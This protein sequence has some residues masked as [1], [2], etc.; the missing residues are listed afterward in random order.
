MK[1]IIQTSI[2]ALE[3]ETENVAIEEILKSLLE[4]ITSYISE[5]LNIIP[6]WQIRKISIHSIELKYGV[7][8]GI[9]RKGGEIRIAN[10]LIM[11]KKSR[12]IR[13][14]L[15]FVVVKVSLIQFITNE[16]DEIEEAFLN[17]LT[18]LWL[19]E[20]F[21]IQST[22]SVIF[23]AI[24]SRIYS[25]SID[26]IDYTHFSFFLNQLFARKK[27]FKEVF[28]VYRNFTEVESLKGKEL[29]DALIKWE[30]SLYSDLEIIAPIYLNEQLHTTI[31]LLLELGCENANVETIANKMNVHPNTVRRNYKI[32][33]DK[34]AI[35]WSANIH[36]EKLNLH[37]YF[38]KII[39]NKT[40]N[41]EKLTRIVW[42]KLPYNN[43]IFLGEM[44][45][46]NK[47]IYS[48]TLFCPHIVAENLDAKLTKLSNLGEITDYS[49]REI[50]EKIHY[51]AITTAPTSPTLKYFK[52]ILKTDK[53]SKNLFAYTY[54]HWKENFTLEII[55]K[56][57]Q[58]DYNLLFFLSIITNKPLLK[59]GLSIRNQTALKLF[60]LNNIALTNT[61]AQADFLN[62]LEIRAK[63]RGLLNYSFSIMKKNP[64]RSDST[65]FEIPTV[66]KQS[67]ERLLILINQFIKF[68]IFGVIILSDR[69]IGLMTGI[70][71]T[72]PVCKLIKDILEKNNFEPIT[73]T[74]RLYKVKSYQFHDLY[75]FSENR[76]LTNI[77]S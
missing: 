68:S 10:S 55:D 38:L 34:F 4:E 12:H 3:K 53:Q 24:N 21:N 54:S 20:N 42:N 22:D 77:E 13:Y 51:G 58:F 45:N 69:V 65:I 75:D 64:R 2:N 46:F 17:V 48:P 7:S 71:H 28:E 47:I 16:I 37:R 50:R 14:L 32:L 39:T 18:V 15:Y 72:H 30:Y 25:S 63:R 70:T 19:R 36:L 49:L 26:G 23:R 35:H 43:R 57:K 60:E 44:N 11:T 61:I 27:K 56:T 62:Q 6:K 33:M 5:T 66:N 73:Y 29:F 1:K 67:E 52:K 40:E 59:S 41:I 31:Q 9:E 76:W 8:I 74:I